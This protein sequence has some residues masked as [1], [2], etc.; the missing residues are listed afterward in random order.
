MEICARFYKQT[1]PRDRE[2][3]RHGT[4]RSLNRQPPHRSAAA[5]PH[6][7]T[8]TQHAAPPPPCPLT[9][10]AA[11]RASPCAPQPSPTRGSPAHTFLMPPPHSLP[12]LSSLSARLRR[13][14]SRRA[15]RVRARLVVD[16]RLRHQLADRVLELVDAHAHLVDCARSSSSSSSSSS[17]KRGV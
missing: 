15:L 3:A 6:T 14:L 11:S 13:W 17:T 4:E 12:H 7:H 5:A 1:K 2:T 8:H 16:A 9:P 10:S